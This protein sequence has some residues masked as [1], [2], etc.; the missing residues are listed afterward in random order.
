MYSGRHDL[1]YFRAPWVSAFQYNAQHDIAFAENPC[2]TLVFHD[3]HTADLGGSHKLDGLHDSGCPRYSQNRP[4]DD[5]HSVPSFLCGQAY[6]KT[7]ACTIETLHW[8]V[9]GFERVVVGLQ[10]TPGSVGRGGK[11]TTDILKS[12]LSQ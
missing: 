2:D 5:G 3:N 4:A 8:T 1:F 6:R 7:F 10:L 11:T 9:I 12:V